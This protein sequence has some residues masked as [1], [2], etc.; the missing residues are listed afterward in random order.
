MKTCAAIIPQYNQIVSIAIKSNSSQP[1]PT[2]KRKI[3]GN[4]NTQLQVTTKTHS[5]TKS[6][7]KQL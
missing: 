1:P 5:L 2:Q 6:V 7:F 3:N 4:W